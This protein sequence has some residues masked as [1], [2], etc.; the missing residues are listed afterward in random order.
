MR[1]QIFENL[2]TSQIY[3]DFQ[4]YNKSYFRILMWA[5]NIYCSQAAFE[6]ADEQ[7]LLK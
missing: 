5:K 3:I 4:K 7:I 1:K 2:R 6:Q